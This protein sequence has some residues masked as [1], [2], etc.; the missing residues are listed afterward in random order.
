M[1]NFEMFYNFCGDF[2]AMLKKDYKTS[3]LKE[4]GVT[5]PQFCITLFAV[6]M[7]NAN[8]SLNI[9]PNKKKNHQKNTP[10]E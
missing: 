1:D 9:K 10:H 5:F 2:D 3:K 7:E 6:F 4:E 8:E